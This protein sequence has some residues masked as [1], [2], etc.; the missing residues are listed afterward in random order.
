VTLE[1]HTHFYHHDPGGA[2]QLDAEPVVHRPAPESSTA[3]VAVAQ[4]TDAL[5]LPYEVILGPQGPSEYT[6][7]GLLELAEI[8]RTP[9]VIITLIVI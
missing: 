7:G 3:L 8:Q 9:R 4:G 5:T 1:S 2:G 6:N